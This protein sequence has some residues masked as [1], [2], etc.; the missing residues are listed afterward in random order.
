MTQTVDTLI[1]YDQELFLWL[2][3]MHTPWVD[4]L[5]YWIT[6]KVTWIPMYLVL[7]LLTVKAEGKRSLAILVTVLVAVVL[8]DKI[9]S[10]LMKP[11]FLRYRPC[12]EPV[13]AGLVHEVSGC[14]GSYGFASSHAS[15][16]FAV[17][18]VWFTLLKDKVK[19]MWLLLLWAVIYSYSRVYVGVH[20]PGDIIVGAMI[21]ALVAGI[22]NRLYF[23]FLA[24][25]YRNQ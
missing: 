15:T 2:N 10:G 9:T 20:Y 7:V 16:S 3:G 13:L 21:G 14:G 18:V 5:M 6:Y 1:Q 22:C 12:H 23:I 8:A 4:T 24:K 17:A 11:Y 25:Y 19:Y